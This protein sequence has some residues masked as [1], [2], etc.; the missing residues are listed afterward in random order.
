MKLDNQL[1]NYETIINSNLPEGGFPAFVINDSILF[2][3]GSK[4]FM[5]ED[6]GQKEQDYLGLLIMG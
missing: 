5:M 6:I 1:M 3:S 4:V 2:V